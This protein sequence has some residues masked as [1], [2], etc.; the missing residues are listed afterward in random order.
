MRNGRCPGS[1]S[2][3]RT[4]CSGYKPC[5][6]YE[7]CEPEPGVDGS[8]AEVVECPTCGHAFCDVA[9]QHR[10]PCPDHGC[11]LSNGDCLGML[12]RFAAC[13]QRLPV[14]VLHVS[15]S[16]P[17]RFGDRSCDTASGTSWRRR[18][19]GAVGGH[20][21]GSKLFEFFGEVFDLGFEAGHV[22]VHGVEPVTKLSSHSIHSGVRAQ[23]DQV[24]DTFFE[25]CAVG[26]WPA[27][28]ARMP[29]NLPL[30]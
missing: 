7:D 21:W 19:R 14:R 12:P 17:R 1:S 5:H 27:V 23:L 13:W 9:C 24:L 3:S 2:A 25:Q 18:Q 20:T 10:R 15:T 8:Q 11:Q 6:T 4:P 16:L 30:N 26:G 28:V 22:C 29:N